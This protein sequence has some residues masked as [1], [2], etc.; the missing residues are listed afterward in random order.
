ME[1]DRRTLNASWCTVC[2]WFVS[3]WFDKDH[4]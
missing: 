4:L 1:P 3:R 2:R